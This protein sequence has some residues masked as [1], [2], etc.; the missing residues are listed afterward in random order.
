MLCFQRKKNTKHC[1][2]LNKNKGN[3]KHTCIAFQIDF[4]SSY[5]CHE[6]VFVFKKKEDLVR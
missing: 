3:K 2:S 1:L 5:T 4:H 6:N